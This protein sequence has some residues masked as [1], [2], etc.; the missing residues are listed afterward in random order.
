MDSSSRSTA[1]IRIDG[2]ILFGSTYFCDLLGIHYSKIAGMSYFDFVFPEDSD[3]ARQSFQTEHLNSESFTFRLKRLDG[4]PVC[5]D[6]KLTAMNGPE[7]KAYAISAA[8]MNRREGEV[9]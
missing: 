2:R 1:L 4:A 7:E 3:A 8:I 5:V 9:L 6:I